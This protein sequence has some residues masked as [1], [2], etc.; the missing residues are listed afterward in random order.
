MRIEGTPESIA[1]TRVDLKRLP[2][3]HGLDDLDAAHTPAVSPIWPAVPLSAVPYS[4]CCHVL[5]EC[6]AV[7]GV[8]M[9]CLRL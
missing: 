4:C 3:V 5:K 6:L 7:Y 9:E 1:L 8:A 2:G